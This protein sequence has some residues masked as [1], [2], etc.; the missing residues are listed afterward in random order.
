MTDQSEHD[1]P[2][3]PAQEAA[4]RRALASAGGPEPI[5]V[6]VADRLDRVIAGLAA[7]RADAVA[8]GA[9]HP[10]AEGVVVRMDPAARRR[11]TRV[12]ALL[13]AAAVVV[14]GGL[15]AGVLSDRGLGRS[16]LASSERLA[17]DRVQ[18][19]S[20]G[21]LSADTPG[22]A[23]PEAGSHSG[24]LT[25]SQDGA[26]SSAG[27]PPDRVI[28]QEPLRPVRPDQLRA[29]LIAVQRASIPGPGSAD[30]AHVTLTAPADF[31]C[32]P[33]DYGPGYLVGIQ[34]AGQPAI[35]AYREPAGDTQV[36]E[37][38]ACGTADLLHSTTLPVRR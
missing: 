29:D 10:V 22:A 27:A 14:A 2:L 28:T 26:G 13:A 20:P 17:D 7:E 35:A 19:E 9:A 21:A 4:V 11:R 1:P 30:Y 16:D 36:A 31:V 38:L 34:Y 37:V 23:A 15:G 25:G 3:S 12:R 18:R 33:A 32:P 8:A 5:P 24:G 6:D